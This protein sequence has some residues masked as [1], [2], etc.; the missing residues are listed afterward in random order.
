MKNKVRVLLVFGLLLVM[1]VVTFA[2]GATSSGYNEPI[3]EESFEFDAVLNGDQVE[4]SWTSFAPEGFNYYKVVRSTTNPDPVYPDD[5]YIQ[6][7]SD[8]DFT[9]YTDE[10]V[11]KG[12]SYYRVC[13]FL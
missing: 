13:R 8:P 7:T 2:T 4:T 3:M 5:G 11:L 12:V 1:P 10:G 9:F 6:V